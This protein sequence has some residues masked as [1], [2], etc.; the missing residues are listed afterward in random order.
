MAIAD[1]VRADNARAD[2]FLKG[3]KRIEAYHISL[4][5]WLAQN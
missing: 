3:N 2:L 5:Q 1:I 4:Q